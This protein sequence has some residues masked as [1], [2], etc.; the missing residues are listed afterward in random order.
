[1]KSIKFRTFLLIGLSA[2][3]VNKTRAQQNRTLPDF[4]QIYAGQVFNMEL[5]PA[6][7]N[8]IYIE[9]D[10]ASITTEVMN[11]TLYL[12]TS[13]KSSDDLKV[14]IYFKEL[15]GIQLTGAATA[16]NK[17]TMF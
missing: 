14:K 16:S 3:I 8:A 13:S 11:G 6:D 1:M 5:F 9:D 2:L 17:D 15:D 10:E 4:K 7:R 12:K